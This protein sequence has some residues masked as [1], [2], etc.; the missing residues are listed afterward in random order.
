MEGNLYENRIFY[1]LKLGNQ[2][3]FAKEI[4]EINKKEY[5][6]TLKAYKTIDH[7][8]L[9]F[10]YGLYKNKFLLFE[11]VNNLEYLRNVNIKN[12]GNNIQLFK[13]G[14]KKYYIDFEFI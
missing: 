7:E 2:Y 8:N 4:E 9:L 13:S 10:F 5:N 12:L 14:N 3:F 1:K 11:W 6:N